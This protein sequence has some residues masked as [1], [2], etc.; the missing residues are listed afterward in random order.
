MAAGVGIYGSRTGFDF[1][2]ISF[3][4]NDSSVLNKRMTAFLEDI[5]FKD[6]QKAS[7]YHSPEDQK[8]ANIPELIE[9]KFFVKP[10]LMDI[11]ELQIQEIMIDS[12]GDRARIHTM[13]HIK[14]LNSEEMRD[15]ESIY[16]W[17]KKDG[18][19]Y[20]KLKSSL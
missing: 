8:S 3:F 17:H 4:N 5:Q 2:D 14:M 7:S 6:F 12:S 13:T 9:S 18:V 19:W 16:F 15:I 10:E 1:S 11:R 20:M